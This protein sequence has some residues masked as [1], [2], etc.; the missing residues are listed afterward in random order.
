MALAGK[1]VGVIDHDVP[2]HTSASGT[3][4]SLADPP[5]AA[6]KLSE[7]HDTP[8][9]KPNWKPPAL[10]VGRTDLGAVP[11]LSQRVAAATGVVA[12]HGGAGVGGD[13]E[14]CADDP[15]GPVTRWRDHDEPSHCSASPIV[16]DPS[17]AVQALA[18]VHATALRVLSVKFCGFGVS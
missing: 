13:A 5:T 8:L 4:C 6:Q 15:F 12:P 14:R 10:G 2:F 1:G 11:H 9:R 18:E 7:A 17:T 16:P 3:A